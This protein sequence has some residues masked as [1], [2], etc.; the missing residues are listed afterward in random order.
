MKNIVFGLDLGAGVSGRIP[1]K[2]KRQAGYHSENK[3]VGVTFV[4]FIW[5]SALD[6]VGPCEMSRFS[7][8]VLRLASFS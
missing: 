4:V 3:N 2:A 8:L 5:D 7:V 1:I 6:V